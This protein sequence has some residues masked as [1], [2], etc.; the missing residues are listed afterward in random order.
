M[1]YLNINTWARKEHF[2]FF[3]DFNDPYF[4]IVTEIDCTS[5]YNYCK[6]NQISF[7]A[8]Y[9]HKSLEA[10]NTIEEFRYRIIDN[11]IAIYNKIHAAVTIG[12]DDGTFAF[13]FVEFISNFND[14]NRNLQKEIDKV[15]KSAGLFMYEDK[16]RKDVIHFSS[17]PWIKFTGLTHAKNFDKENSTPL[18]V[19]G[20]ITNENNKVTMP[21]AINA[22][23]ALMDAL[24]V[25]IFYKHFENILRI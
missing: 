3:K 1:K 25:S 7:F 13:T 10:V 17:T 16:I 6:E 2:E 22:H 18:I 14:F 21:V 15:K 12:R 9:L 23:H 20:K 19:F 5:A 24:H 8:Y 4:G 11:K